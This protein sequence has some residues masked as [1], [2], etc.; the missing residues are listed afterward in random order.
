MERFRRH[1]RDFFPNPLM[2]K[3]KKK[4]SAQQ[5]AFMQLV[6]EERNAALTE[7]AKQIGL[8]LV[9]LTSLPM[10]LLR[11]PPEESP[12]FATHQKILQMGEIILPNFSAQST[13]V[14]AATT[15]TMTRDE[16]YGDAIVDDH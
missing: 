15:A 16:S 7:R 3:G 4:L 1:S 5:I 6:G 10:M 2:H 14:P 13:S 8:G 11:Q 12:M 9:P